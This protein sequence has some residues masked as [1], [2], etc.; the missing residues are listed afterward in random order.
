MAKIVTSA[1]KF[2]LEAWTDGSP[3]WVKV[4]IEGQEVERA[5]LE[6]EDLPDLIHAAQRMIA[7]AARG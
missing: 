7:K 4:R 2:E 5:F 1:G 6:V 3:L